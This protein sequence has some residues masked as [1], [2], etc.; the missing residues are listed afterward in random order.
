MQI[1]GYGTKPIAGSGLDDV[2]AATFTPEEILAYVEMRLND[3]DGQIQDYWKDA[4][5]KKAHATELRIFQEAVRSL[6]QG[7]T[8]FDS[9]GIQDNVTREEVNAEAQNK[10]AAALEQ[11][12]HSENPELVGRL[13][14]LKNYLDGA[15]GGTPGKIPADAL[16]HSLDYAKDQLAEL[17]GD[18]E[19]TM[20][21][22]NQLMQLR[23]QIISAASNQLAS[24]N[25]AVKN[26]INNMRS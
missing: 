7:P 13:T 11:L 2:A 23:S 16:Q 17:N 3:L 5:G 26:I 24:T 19:L 21:R 15:N 18:N 12:R 20:M 4:Q 8:G 9:T 22:L 1:C 25:E 10:I 14:A 6:Q